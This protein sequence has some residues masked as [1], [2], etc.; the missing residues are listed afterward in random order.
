MA[1]SERV[2]KIVEL[3][4]REKP[5]MGQNRNRKKKKDG[6]RSWKYCRHHEHRESKCKARWETGV[7]VSP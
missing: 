7:V 5:L 6:A 3:N 4:K 1:S 2:M